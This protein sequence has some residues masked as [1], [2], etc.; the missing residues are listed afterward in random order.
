MYT[1]SCLIGPQLTAGRGHQLRPAIRLS[2]AAAPLAFTERPVA[3]LARIEIVGIVHPCLLESLVLHGSPAAVRLRIVK[4]RFSAALVLERSRSACFCL[5][6][7]Q[8]PDID[9]NLGN[10]Q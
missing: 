10:R 8:P 7:V 5:A 6:I 1:R 3:D 2:P 4:T 9:A